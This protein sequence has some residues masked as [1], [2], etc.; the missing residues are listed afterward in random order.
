MNNIIAKL[1]SDL[2]SAAR[3]PMRDEDGLVCHP[4]IDLIYELLGVDDEG[5]ASN[6]FIKELGY[7]SYQVHMEVDAPVLADRY[8]ENE[9]TN[10]SQWTPSKPDG[11]GW[12]LV[13][14]VDTEDGPVA[15]YVRKSE[16]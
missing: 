16:D 4:D 12:L 11:E 10:C 6:R 2:F 5:E 9:S 8:F 7:K 15:C 1:P 13:C 14:I 3:L